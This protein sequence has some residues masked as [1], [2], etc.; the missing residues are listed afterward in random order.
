M[1]KHVV[2]IVDLV[3]SFQTNIY[4]QNLASIQPRTSP[5]TNTRYHCYSYPLFSAQPPPR[6]HDPDPEP[7]EA[8]PAHK[9]KQRLDCGT[10]VSDLAA[11]RSLTVLFGKLEHALLSFKNIALY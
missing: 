7:V 11:W 5:N 2:N 10:L 1:Q 9:P 6:L 3:K 4:L 8:E